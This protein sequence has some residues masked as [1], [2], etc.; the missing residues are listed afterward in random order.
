ME[1]AQ[2][3]LIRLVKVTEA[4]YTGQLLQTHTGIKVKGHAQ[5]APWTLSK[6]NVCEQCERYEK[7][8]QFMWNKIYTFCHF[9]QWMG[10]KIF[11]VTHKLHKGLFTSLLAV[12]GLRVEGAAVCN[13]PISIMHFLGNFSGKQQDGPE[14]SKIYNAIH[15]PLILK[16]H[17][18]FTWAT[19]NK[20]KNNNRKILG[21]YPVQLA[22][23]LHVS[24]NKF[25][26]PTAS[27]SSFGSEKKIK[28]ILVWYCANN[29]N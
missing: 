10:S 18:L 22:L 11:A 23:K 20:Q 3:Q 25:N 16:N 24:K 14:I 7:C 1:N 9:M 28:C 4:F 26:L 8:C 2:L 19:V 17:V 5:F 29:K 13:H 21:F 6:H 27:E 12:M 15:N